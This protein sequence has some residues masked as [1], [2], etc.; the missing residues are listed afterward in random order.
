MHT[1]NLYG[2]GRFTYIAILSIEDQDNYI[3]IDE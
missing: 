3:A 2:I 1:H